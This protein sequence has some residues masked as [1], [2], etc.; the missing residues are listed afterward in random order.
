MAWEHMYAPPPNWTWEGL[1]VSLRQT[2][3]G[4][5]QVLE[6]KDNVGRGHSG[7]VTAYATRL[8]RATGLSQTDI[9][10]FGFGTLIHDIGKVAISDGILQKPGP[11]SA[12][13]YKAVQAHPVVGAWMLRPVFQD[14]EPRVL[15]VV[16]CHH[17]RFD[18]T[19]YPRALAGK[20]I[21]LWG[22]MCAI[23]DAWDVMT[24]PR[25]YRSVFSVEQAV[26]ELRR[27]SGTHFDPELTALFVDKVVPNITAASYMRR[28]REPDKAVGEVAREGE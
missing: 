17:E 6:A 16:L 5:V 14:V 12:L 1:P 15:D 19:G 24:S 10:V 27:C 4:I 18:G 20:A 28:A 2:L 23:A 8:A 26:A 22:R 3:L 21:P 11:L 7:R 25:S 13:E 9:H